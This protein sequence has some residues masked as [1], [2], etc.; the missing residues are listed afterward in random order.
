MK[1]FRDQ[2]SILYIQRL[3]LDASNGECAFLMLD[4]IAILPIDILHTTLLEDVP[5]Y[6]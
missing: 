5:K 6:T 1:K 3:G 2:V 4:L